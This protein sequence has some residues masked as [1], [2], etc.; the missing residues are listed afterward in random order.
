MNENPYICRH[1]RH[2]FRAEARVYA[3]PRCG[4]LDTTGYDPSSIF[5]MLAAKF[6]GGGG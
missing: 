3:C 1:C 2:E 6:S 5:S 4:S